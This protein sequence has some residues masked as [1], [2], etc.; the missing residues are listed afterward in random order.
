MMVFVGFFTDDRAAAMSLVAIASIAELDLALRPR[1]L[2]LH[3]MLH[4]TSIGMPDVCIRVTH[5]FVFSIHTFFV[6]FYV[7]VSID[8]SF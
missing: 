2:P 1:L 5:R 3:V 6:F 8:D 4:D 7:I